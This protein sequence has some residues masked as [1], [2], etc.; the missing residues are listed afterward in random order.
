MRQPRVEI[1]YFEG[2]P[3]H[4]PARALDHF[5]C[6][7]WVA[8][9]DGN[10]TGGH[11]NVDMIRIEIQRNAHFVLSVVEFAVPQQHVGQT[12]VRVAI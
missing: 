10:P 12:G 6:A 5:N 1:L 7:F 11:D 3:S 9:D 4:E 2:C 8:V